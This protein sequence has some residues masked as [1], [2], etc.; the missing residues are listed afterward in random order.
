MLASLAIRDIVLIDRLDLTLGPGLSVLTGETGAG[1]SI[2]LDALGLALGARADAGLVRA[3]SEQGSVAASFELPPAHPAFGLL[4]DQGIDADDGQIIL[5]RTLGADGRSR[6]FVNDQPVSVALL[7]QVGAT[8]IDIHGQNDEQGLMDARTHRLLL[9]AFAQAEAEVEAVRAAYGVLRQAARD[10]AAAQEEA[11]RAA[12]DEDYLRHAR[13]ELDRLDPQPGEEA[14]LAARRAIMQN[15]EK[16]VAALT[17]A[18]SALDESDGAV[19][20]LRF[21]LRSLE[22][23]AD[24]AGGAFNEA[25]DALARALDAASEGAA[26]LDAAAA[27]LDVNPGA[28]E[29]AEERLFALRALARK[30]QTSVDELAALR[31]DIVRKLSAIEDGGQSLARL[32]AAH[33]AAQAAWRKAAQA[34]SAKRKQAAAKL[35]KAVAKELE[36]LRLG[37]AR[38]VTDL[39]TLP[40]DEASAD[41]MDRVTFLAIT[42]AGATPAPLSKIAS[43]GELS[44]FMLALR[45]TLAGRGPAGT[46]VFD[47][48]DRGVGGATAAAVGERLAKL[49][50]G[51]QLLVITHSP[52]VAARAAQHFQI[53]KT[54]IGTG[55]GR[56]AVT[57]V[58]ALNDAERREEIARM[59]AG[60]TVTEEA[61]AAAKKLLEAAVA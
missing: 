49:A 35:D 16:L 61:R 15:A 47:E 25:L 13:E 14:E 54:E 37:A 10:W 57:Q 48:V 19:A 9:D 11:T 6:A 3:G 40:E 58:R 42:N 18:Q 46:L 53:A 51:Q 24:K 33:R 27:R 12:R 50:R 17:D 41:G 45:V 31:D 21:A 23:L 36:P 32:E 55:K 26:A 59:L 28:L 8:L 52:Q 22:R 7:R 20:R 34:L 39:Q 43:G 60:E 4:R 30:H 56:M 2:L 5:R 38:L 44:R 29:T 1:K